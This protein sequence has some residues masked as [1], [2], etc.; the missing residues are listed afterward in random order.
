MGKPSIALAQAFYA[1]C[2]ELEQKDIICEWVPRNEPGE[3]LLAP[4]PSKPQQVAAG[5][6]CYF[7]PMVGTGPRLKSSKSP[8]LK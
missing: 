2:K 3:G 1:D 5:L 8:A 4:S 7:F 6:T